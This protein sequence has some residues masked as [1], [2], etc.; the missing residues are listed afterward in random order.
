MAPL[1][2]LYRKANYVH[3]DKIRNTTS[4]R[5]SK[6]ALW[7]ARKLAK[8]FGY[9]EVESVPVAAVNGYADQWL[10]DSGSAF[11]II[12]PSQIP[13]GAEISRDTPYT[14][15]TAN[16]V[17]TVNETVQMRPYGSDNPTTALVMRDSPTVLSMGKRCLHE[18][19]S[20]QWMAGRMPTLTLPD[21][22]VITLNV[23]NG[24]PLL[25]MDNSGIVG[26][27][28][29]ACA[30]PSSSESVEEKFPT[31]EAEVGGKPPTLG[32][33]KIP[34]EHFL[35]HLPKHPKCP[36]CQAARM[37]NR[38]CRRQKHDEDE[39]PTTKR[40]HH[41]GPYCESRRRSRKC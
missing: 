25:P 3:T 30:G 26:A 10:L 6:D 13:K 22:T 15:S 29:P 39:E 38:Q 23:T 32:G 40:P 9:Q 4:A 18:G 28:P 5:A 37:Q 41:C 27:A 7:R 1:G 16:G 20:F 31:E 35:T 11:D 34:D 14:L 33:D 21:G 24:V 19:Y 12:S 36:A 17:V 2:P 8:E